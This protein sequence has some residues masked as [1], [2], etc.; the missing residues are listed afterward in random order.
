MS[1]NTIAFSMDGFRRNLHRDLAE[2]KEQINNVLNDEWFDKD[3]LKNAMDEIISSSN[4]LNCVS[5][6]GDKMFT[7]MENLYLPLI[8]E[9]ENR[10]E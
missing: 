9:D 4:S 6:E 3:D 8:D 7:N 2:L 5:I 1:V 10:D